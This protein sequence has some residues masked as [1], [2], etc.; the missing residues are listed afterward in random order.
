MVGNH[1]FEYNNSITNDLILFFSPIEFS[2]DLREHYADKMIRVQQKVDN[3][4][5][6]ALG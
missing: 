4:K 1:P 5:I 3:L 6:A 2:Q